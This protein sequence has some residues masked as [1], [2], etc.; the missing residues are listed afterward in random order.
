MY[1][2]K[3]DVKFRVLNKYF[4]CKNLF[5]FRE[6][7]RQ[8]WMTTTFNIPS[9]F[10]EISTPPTNKYKNQDE[11]FGTP[12]SYLSD[13]TDDS[14]LYQTPKQYKSQISNISSSSS[15][16]KTPDNTLNTKDVFSENFTI[17]KS[18]T[19]SNFYFETVELRVPLNDILQERN[20][21]NINNKILPD[22]HSDS[23]IKQ[24][25]T[26]GV[27]R[28]KSDFE[29]P[30]IIPIVKSESRLQNLLQKSD[31]VFSFL[32][33]LT[34]RRNGNNHSTPINNS[35]N[36]NGGFLIPNPIP[37]NHSN[38]PNHKTSS[39]NSLR[40]GIVVGEP[41]IPSINIQR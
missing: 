35:V 27:S 34:K 38:F 30:K 2:Y 14:N 15:E 12:K 8:K 37:K 29:I 18:S 31:S 40:A 20:N 28:S 11:I 10:P 3:V 19:I 33:P 4:A 25:V 23:K 17:Q 22:R 5:L 36:K 41:V 13:T 16:Y 39:L 21:L 9:T 7:Q 6:I 1:I 32:T 24:S 26:E